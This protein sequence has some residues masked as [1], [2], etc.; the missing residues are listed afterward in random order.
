MVGLIKNTISKSISDPTRVKMNQEEFNTWIAKV[1]QTANDRP[2]V[3]GL[4]EGLTITPNNVLLGFREN[5]SKIEN[6]I[7]Q[8]GIS[9]QIQRWRNAMSLFYRYWDQEFAGRRYHVKGQ[10]EFSPKIGDYVLFRNEPIYGHTH[11]IAVVDEL[12]RR[13][14]NDV[15]A[16]KITY[17]RNI[18]SG[19]RTVVRHLSDLSEFMD[20]ELVEKWCNLPRM[21]DHQPI[22][23][24]NVAPED[25]I[26]NT[27]LQT[28]SGQSAISDHHIQDEV[29]GDD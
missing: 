25:E 28:T 3:L 15:Y 14:N 1:M 21:E 7:P 8:P 22:Q 5:Y 13:P 24:L 10:K 6:S 18:N 29:F 11:T 20:A 4:P 9:S 23:H 19:S 27:E 26:T 16:A 2:L 12:I 17:K